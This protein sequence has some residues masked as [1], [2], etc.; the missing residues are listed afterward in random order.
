[1]KLYDE[2]INR[3]SGFLKDRSTINLNINKQESWPDVGNHQMILR[4]DMAYELGGSTPSVYAIGSTAVTADESLVSADEIVL[5]GPDISEI[6]VD[7]SFARLTV[8]LVDSEA[9]GDGNALYNAVKKIN[10]VGYHVNPEGY[11][12]RLS[13]VYGR[14]SIRISKPAI[15]KGLSFEHVGNLMLNE[16][17]KNPVV[18]AVKLV[19]VTDP[20]FDYKAASAAAADAASITATIDHIMKDAMTD[21]NT[22]GLKK[23][24]DE[25]EGLREMHFGRSKE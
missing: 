19:Y 25:V 13:S 14:E 22:C 10:N 3:W 9:M 5:V 2:V 6:K 1:M 8:V 24:C 16:L 20:S 7:V 21:C 18:K 11:M 17:H 23:V 15:E 4:G 12:M